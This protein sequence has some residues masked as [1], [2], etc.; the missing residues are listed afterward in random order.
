MGTCCQLHVHSMSSFR[1]GLA[2]EA[3]L[4]ARAK[5]LGQPGIGLTNHGNLYG[6][7]AFFKACQA[8]GIS[9]MIGMEAYEAV[10]HTFDIETDIEIFKVK[11]ADLGDRD[12]YYHIT[13]WAFNDV[14]WRNLCAMH[15]LSYGATHLPAAGARSKPL[16]DRAML[17]KHNEG[18]IIGLGCM[19]SR[20][21]V[22]IARSNGDITAAYEASKWVAEHFQ[23]R[24]YVEVMGNT[25]EQVALI[26]PQR[27]LAAKLGLP[28]VATNDV[29]YVNQADGVEHGVHHILV[30]S[31]RWKKAD[32]E[33]TNDK[34]DDGFGQWYGSDGF[35]MKSFEEML[36]TGGLQGDEIERSVEILN[37]NTF[38]FSSI[39][40]PQPPHIAAPVPG[41][42]AEFDRW[43]AHR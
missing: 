24:A 32:V 9:G 15:T 31:R 21:N 4:V 6:A 3:E 5:E 40:E 26:N 22:L 38:D 29:H 36:A 39:P 30:K 20:A 25:T 14:G 37:R 10:P 18:V 12:R 17:E 1:D 8:H 34:S 19:A 27:K 42:D 41:E 2:P 43:L 28:T 33:E 16:I 13:L 11:W 7:P 35:Y 23:G